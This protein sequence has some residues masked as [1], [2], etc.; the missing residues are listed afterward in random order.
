MAAYDPINLNEHINLNI[1]HLAQ[2][3]LDSDRLLLGTAQEKGLS[4]GTIVN[5]IISSYDDDFPLTE[6]LIKKKDYQSHKKMRLSRSAM[7]A[8][9]DY[10]EN[11]YPLSGKYSVTQYIKCLLESYARINFIEREKLILKKTV[12]E[13]IENS[14]RQNKTIRIKISNQF[15]DLSPYKI[16]PSKEGT[17]QYLVG[18]VD[19]KW[20]AYRLS[21][22]KFLK[23]KGMATLPPVEQIDEILAEFGPTFFGEPITDIKVRFT[24]KGLLRYEYSVIHR[25][26]HTKIENDPKTNSSIYIFNCSEK[27][28]LYFFFSFAN[29]VE[30][31]EPL[32]LRQRFIDMYQQGYQKYYEKVD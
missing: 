21:R 5:T 32:S 30:I 24:P 28:A 7:D 17:F 31:I 12:I 22:I 20:A 11:A 3:V 16:V 29:D 26:V 2:K 19:G 9:T 10:E 27:Q 13:P 23:T 14:I 25:P 6:S 8:L 18:A 1:T 15:I 4:F